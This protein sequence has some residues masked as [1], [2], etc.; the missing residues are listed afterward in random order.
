MKEE[1]II[2]FVYG[3]IERFNNLRKMK[4]MFEKD[5]LWFGNVAFVTGIFAGIWIVMVLSLFFK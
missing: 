1:T 4:M 2:K 5:Y 3:S